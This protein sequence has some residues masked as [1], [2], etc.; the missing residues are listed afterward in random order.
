VPI[1]VNVFYKLPT[2]CHELS[3][4]QLLWDSIRRAVLLKR[5]KRCILLRFLTIYAFCL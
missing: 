1:T 4:K 2:G 3:S 5:F